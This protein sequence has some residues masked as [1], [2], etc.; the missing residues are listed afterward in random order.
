M[1]EE[2]SSVHGNEGACYPIKHCD[3]VPLGY[4]DKKQIEYYKM[5]VLNFPQRQI[6]ITW[7]VF[8]NENYSLN[9]VYT[10]Q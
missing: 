6:G 5:Y 10:C 9:I 3:L 7:N 8:V 1:Y 2:L 4:V